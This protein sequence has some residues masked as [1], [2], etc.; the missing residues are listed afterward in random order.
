MFIATADLMQARATE[1]RGCTDDAAIH[2]PGLAHV[3]VCGQGSPEC[4]RKPVTDDNAHQRAVRSQYRA[5]EEGTAAREW[6]LPERYRCQER[7]AAKKAPAKKAATKKPPK[8]PQLKVAAKKTMPA[9]GVR[10]A[11]YRMS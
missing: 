1:N 5:F 7:A 6:R 4:Q 9:R 8:K 2:R 3:L 11:R 10:M